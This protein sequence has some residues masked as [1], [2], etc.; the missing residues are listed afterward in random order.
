[1]MLVTA[2]QN[3]PRS[4]GH[5]TFLG[6]ASIDGAAVIRPCRLASYAWPIP[7]SWGEIPA[8]RLMADVPVSVSGLDFAPLSIAAPTATVIEATVGEKLTIPLA[9][10]RRSEFSGATM[11]L[12]TAGVGFDRVPV[13]TLP[14]TADQSLAVVDLAALKT[15]PGDYLI[16]FYGGAVTKYRHQP[17]AVSAAEAALQSVKQ[18]VLAL[19]AESKKL[20]DEATAAPADKKPAADKLVADVAVRLKAAMA[21]VSAADQK[22]KNVTATAQ[23]RD[24]VDI[25]VSEP[26]AI[27]VKAK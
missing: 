15:P 27:R 14:L 16:A 5:A 22:L 7:D 8:P 21:T 3:A 20:T 12:R 18:E 24:I 19:E 25:V 9:L 10:T 1:M 4:V 17:E 13:I 11:E 23:P 2:N 26:I 6:K